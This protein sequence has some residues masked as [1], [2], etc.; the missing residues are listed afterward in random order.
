[1][2]A[3]RF[4]N[5]TEADPLEMYDR[6][7]QPEGVPELALVVAPSEARAVELLN[8]NPDCRD[9][10]WTI[11]LEREDIDQLPEQVMF[12]QRAPRRP[13]L[14]CANDLFKIPGKLSYCAVNENHPFEFN[15][16]HEV[17][18]EAEVDF[19]LVEEKKN[20][21]VSTRVIYD[22]YI[23]GNRCQTMATIWYNG[24][25]IGI[26]QVGGRSG[27]DFQRRFITNLVDYKNAVE[28]I[29]SL[30]SNDEDPVVSDYLDPEKAT[31]DLNNFY[32]NFVFLGEDR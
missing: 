21:R 32:G 17:F 23:D 10:A 20:T 6:G 4:T 29:R 15:Q 12:V 24:S 19:Y 27:R 22:P 25:P 3:Y 28:Y 8:G 11:R 26:V 18:F 9:L 31:R 1:M 2:N 5:G 16:L 30:Y 13:P 7:E 14:V